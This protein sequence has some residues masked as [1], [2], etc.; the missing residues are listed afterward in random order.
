MKITGK[1]HYGEDEGLPG[2]GSDYSTT[3]YYDE[4]LQGGR[5][6]WI[7]CDQWYYSES[8]TSP[9]VYRETG[10]GWY[11]DSGPDDVTMIRFPNRMAAI[12]A[13]KVLA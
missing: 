6:M 13:M 11:I 12:A 7:D 9:Q 1:H 2:V 10:G 4:C 8:G 3:T 5:M